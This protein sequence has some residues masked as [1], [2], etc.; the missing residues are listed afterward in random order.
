MGL[1]M[2]LLVMVNDGSPP[3]RWD[4]IALP[5]NASVTDR[6]KACV[7]VGGSWLGAY[8]ECDLRTTYLD[9][10]ELFCLETLQGTYDEC[11][12]DCRHQINP[13]VA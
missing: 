12:S 2:G 4:T 3:M 1:M 8:D 9:N 7:D 10:M 11:A 5:D 13:K 6:A